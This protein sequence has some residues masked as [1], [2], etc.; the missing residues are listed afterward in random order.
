MKTPIAVIVHDMVLQ[1]GFN[2][3]DPVGISLIPVAIGVK[4][5]GLRILRGKAEYSAKVIGNILSGGRC[6]SEKGIRAQGQLIGSD[7]IVIV[8]AERMPSL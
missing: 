4:N 7:G 8:L 2:V 6:I 5:A 1:H 3:G